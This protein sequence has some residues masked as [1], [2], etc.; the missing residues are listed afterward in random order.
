MTPT[1]R[2]WIIPDPCTCLVTREVSCI[3]QL[4][5]TEQAE[6]AECAECA[7]SSRTVLF[8]SYISTYSIRSFASFWRTSLV[9]WSVP[10]TLK[11]NR[12]PKREQPKQVNLSRGTVDGCLGCGACGD[13]QDNS[14]KGRIG[15]SP[16]L[17]LLL[18][19]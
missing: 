9:F 12:I 2:L 7:E 13:C 17:Q 5:S 18:G 10:D 14:T 19:L 3:I 15:E 11:V 4:T 1:A 6:C 16:Y 8:C